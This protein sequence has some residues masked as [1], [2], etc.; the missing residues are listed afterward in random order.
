MSAIDLRTIFAA[1]FTTVFFSHCITK[2]STNSSFVPVTL[3]DSNLFLTNSFAHP[4]THA[5]TYSLAL[6]LA[7]FITYARADTCADNLAYARA[8]TC[9]DN[10]AYTLVDN[11]A[12]TDTYISLASANRAD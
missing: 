6:A 11:F 12:N 10:L 3:I 2:L 1:I 4:L 7:F 9:A 8:N 5:S